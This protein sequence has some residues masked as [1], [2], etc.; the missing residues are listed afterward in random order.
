MTAC[1]FRNPNELSKQLIVMSMAKEP[2]VKFRATVIVPILEPLPF[3]YNWFKY[4]KPSLAPAVNALTAFS[5]D[6]LQL[7]EYQASNLRVAVRKT[8]K[9]RKQ[10][11]V[12]IGG[13]K[14]PRRGC[15]EWEWSVD[16]T[17]TNFQATSSDGKPIPLSERVSLH[18]QLACEGF[19]Q[20]VT[21]ILVASQIAQPGVLR[22]YELEMW[23]GKRFLKTTDSIL[24]YL[25]EVVEFAGEKAW[26]KIESL[27]IK[28][29]WQW[30]CF[31]GP[32]S[33]NLG[34]SEIGRALNALTYLLSEKPIE[35][36]NLVDLMW[37]M[38]GL[39][40]LYG[41]G[42]SDLTYQ[43]VEKAGVLLGRSAG[44]DKSVKEMYRFRSLFIHGKAPFPGAFFMSDGTSE[45][46]RHSD[47]ASE[48]CYLAAAVLVASLQQIA[49]R[50]WKSLGFSFVV[51]EPHES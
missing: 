4:F 12:L 49:K 9:S 37:A 28:Q 39:E 38:I 34:Q 26:P 19:A 23:V 17:V 47:E 36:H 29:V 50:N 35:G 15:V 25:G 41:R 32:L 46:E 1:Y 18:V 30:M 10:R 42:A 14:L 3:E 33:D 21:S 16:L 40:A 5:A 11:T 31:F 24:G 48:A 2:P 27:S 22:T 43:L 45:Y 44:F 51:D 13:Q 6:D 20:A 7:T 8:P